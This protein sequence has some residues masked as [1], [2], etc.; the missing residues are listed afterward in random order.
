MKIKYRDKLLHI[1]E[2]I[3]VDEGD[4]ALEITATSKE[5]MNGKE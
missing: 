3:N 5:K 4:F 1:T 2:I